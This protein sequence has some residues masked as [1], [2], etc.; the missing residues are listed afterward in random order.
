MSGKTFSPDPHTY[1]ESDGW[2]LDFLAH[3][4]IDLQD[5]LKTC[6]IKLICHDQLEFAEIQ[7]KHWQKICSHT[8][9]V[10]CQQRGGAKP[11]RP[12]SVMSQATFDMVILYGI[13]VFILM[14]F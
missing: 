8:G 3:W 4:Q 1:P 5:L 11:L 9:K 6:A 13:V 14:V 7:L 12:P 10:A 2:E